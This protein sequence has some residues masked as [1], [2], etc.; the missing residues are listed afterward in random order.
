MAE[1]IVQEY[2][3]LQKMT[4]KISQ[5][6]PQ[7]DLAEDQTRVDL[8]EE[9]SLTYCASAGAGRLPGGRA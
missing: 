9:T 7:R 4:N 1:A 8:L 5:I 3:S 2:P 6:L